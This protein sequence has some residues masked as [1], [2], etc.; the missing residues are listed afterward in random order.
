GGPKNAPAQ[1]AD[2]YGARY[3]TETEKGVGFARNVGIKASRG[4]IVAFTD[5]DCTVSTRWLRELAAAFADE[6]VGAV[7]GAI[8]PY[9]P[10]TDAERYAA[11]RLSHSQ[12]RPLSD[13]DRPF[14]M[15]PNLAP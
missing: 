11:R 14:A 10:Q 7:A 3:V 15:M 8:L 12:L 13:P 1:T 6:T 2:R 9:P 4:E 5:A